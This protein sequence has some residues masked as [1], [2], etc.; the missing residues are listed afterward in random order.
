MKRI[1]VLA[2]F[3]VVF[4]SFFLGC[5]TT[6]VKYD[7]DAFFS[8]NNNKGEI[9]I[10]LA[11]AVPKMTLVMDDKI[12]VDSRFWGTKRV[13][14]KNVPNGE[15]KIKAFADSWQ[16]KENFQFEQTIEVKKNA[17]VPIM[18]QVPQYSTMYWIYVI[19][20]AIVSALPSIIVYQ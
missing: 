3:F 17:K 15:H 18:V 5:A 8:L 4:T 13:D 11:R 12:L 2:M 20:I 9:N 10:L 16:L 14:I 7:E 19:G 1:T 6:S